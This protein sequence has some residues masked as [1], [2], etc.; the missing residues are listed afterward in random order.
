MQTRFTILAFWVILLA[1]CAP[2]VAP[3]TATPMPTAT[4]TSVPLTPTPPPIVATPLPA[5][6]FTPIM[7]P[8]ATQVAHW[9]EYQTA[10]ANCVFR[11]FGDAGGECSSFS[12]TN[13]LCEWDILGRSSQEVYVWAQCENGNVE[14]EKPLVVYLETDGSIQEVKFGGYKGLD[15]NLDLFSADVQEKILH[16]YYNG[17]SLFHGRIREMLDHLN[18][19]KTHLGELPLIVL[20][21]TPQP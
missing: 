15:Y 6:S 2:L 16:L 21:A 5:Q 17:D 1:S 18:Y 10:L 14:G 13:A 11:E 4:Y 20:S 7:T 8:D 9:K 12:F 19:R 3:P